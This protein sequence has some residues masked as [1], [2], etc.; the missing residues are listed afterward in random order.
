[1]LVVGKKQLPE[2]THGYFLFIEGTNKNKE[3]LLNSLKEKS[4]KVGKGK[5][6]DPAA[7]CLAEGKFIFAN[8]DKH[9]HFI[10]QITNPAQ[11]KEIQQEFNL[12]KEDDYLISVKN[13]EFGTMLNP[14]EKVNYPKN[15]QEKFSNYK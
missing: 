14:K 5:T 2:G 8:H 4:H 6:T 9:T 3:E 15:L 1:L 7:H 13:P 12:Q 11:L 10:Y